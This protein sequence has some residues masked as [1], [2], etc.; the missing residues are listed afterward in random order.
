MTV[1]DG[2]FGASLVIGLI[3]LYLG[4]KDRWRWK[5]IAAWILGCLLI[6]AIG[7]GSWV[8]WLKWD[9]SRPVVVTE[10]WGIKLGAPAQEVL[11]AKGE[12]TNRVSANRWEYQSTGT[13]A[14]GVVVNFNDGKVTS[15]LSLGDRL[16]M[17]TPANLSSFTSQEEAFARFGQP[18]ESGTSD[19]GLVR[20]YGFSRY[21]VLLSFNKDGLIAAGMVGPGKTI[22][23]FG[24][25]RAGSPQAEPPS[26]AGKSA[27]LVEEEHR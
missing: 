8:G 21:N 25:K 26:A 23:I 12:P 2:I 24:K 6:L 17:P 27:P 1:G 15:V 19:D 3:A 10:F 18:Q 9:E 13:D 20:T 7:T 4:T 11:F 22:P 5:R 14:Y 16:Y